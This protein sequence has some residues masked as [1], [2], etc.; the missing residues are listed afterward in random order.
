MAAAINDR[1]E[2]YEDTLAAIRRLAERHHVDLADIAIPAP[3]GRRRTLECGTAVV[4]PNRIQFVIDGN[5]IPLANVADAIRLMQQF[6]PPAADIG[7]GR[8][9]GREGC[10]RDSRP[11]WRDPL[12]SDSGATACLALPTVGANRRIGAPGPFPSEPASG[13]R[14][15]KPAR[16]RSTPSCGTAPSCMRGTAR[17]DIACRVEG[18]DV[19]AW[20][21]IDA[22]PVRTQR[23]TIPADV[24]SANGTIDLEFSIS[25]PRSPAEIGASSDVRLLGI[26]IE[27]LSFR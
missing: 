23:L 27:T 25:E 13:C 4:G 10:R 12:R 2:F 22:A 16:D 24:V 17:L 9:Q 1:L 6:M 26:G 21:C 8:D 7:S 11:A 5:A 19:A 15:G 20:S 18:Q 3:L 14:S